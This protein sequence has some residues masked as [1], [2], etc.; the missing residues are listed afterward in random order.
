MPNEPKA[1]G[2]GYAIERVDPAQAF[3]ESATVR[4]RAATLHFV[5][6]RSAGER[7][8]YIYLAWRFSSTAMASPSESFF[9]RN[10]TIR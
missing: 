7:R 6:T 4:R 5:Q 9:T 10:N 3:V 1:R 8:P 2:C